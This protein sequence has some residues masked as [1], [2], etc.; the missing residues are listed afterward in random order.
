MLSRLCSSI[1][2][3]QAYMHMHELH[4]LS[5][6]QSMHRVE[7]LHT[8]QSILVCQ[9]YMHAL[10]SACTAQA[11]ASRYLRALANHSQ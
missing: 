10:H 9:A 7:R 11:S 8:A 6:A 4:S 2:V 1:L 3:Q 5:T